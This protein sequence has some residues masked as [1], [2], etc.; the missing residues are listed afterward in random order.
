MTRSSRAGASSPLLVPAI[1]LPYLANSTGWIFT[2]IGR[3]PWIVFGLH[4]DRRAASRQP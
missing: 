2:E 3:A 4:E 1:V